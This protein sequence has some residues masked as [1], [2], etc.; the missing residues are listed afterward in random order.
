MLRL[1]GEADRGRD[2]ETA[3]RLDGWMVRVKSGGQCVA[4]D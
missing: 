2:G 3:G 1:D 4:G